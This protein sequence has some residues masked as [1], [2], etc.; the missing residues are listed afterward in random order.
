MSIQ[1]I[2]LSR[3]KNL[4]YLIDYKYGSQSSFAA[5]L[6][7]PALT[8]PTLSDIL[9][10]KRPLHEFEARAIEDKLSIPHNWMDRDNWI[11]DGRELIDKYKIMTDDEKVFFNK[12]INFVVNKYSKA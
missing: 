9:R 4:E 3:R 5:I 6:K 2:I 11:Y 10:K 1:N 12:T 7:Y 8:Q